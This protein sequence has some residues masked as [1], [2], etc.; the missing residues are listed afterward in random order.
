MKKLQVKRYRVWILVVIVMGLLVGASIVEYQRSHQSEKSAAVSPSPSPTINYGPPTKQ[1]IAD[2]EE[3]KKELEQARQNQ[4][5]TTPGVQKS[6]GPV[7]SSWGQDPGSKDLEIAAFVPGIYED[8]GTC[9]LTLTKAG[10]VLTKTTAGHKD[11]NRTSC[12]PF[13][14]AQ[15]ELTTGAWK[16]VIHYDSVTASGSSNQEMINVKIGS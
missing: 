15:D 12:E 8:G 2:S 4:P 10:V 14:I 7:I 13:T 5:S 1:E 11:V 16:A 9:I 3:H 6:V